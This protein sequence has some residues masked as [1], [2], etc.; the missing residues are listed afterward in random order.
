MMEREKF[1]PAIFE[2]VLF[3]FTLL[4]SHGLLLDGN[5]Y[6][7]PDNPRYIHTGEQGM[8]FVVWQVD[9]RKKWFSCECGLHAKQFSPK[10]PNID[11]CQEFSRLAPTVSSY[12]SIIQPPILPWAPCI[13]LSP[14]LWLDSSV[15]GCPLPPFNHLK[16]FLDEAGLLQF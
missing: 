7:V 13:S 11:L 8:I 2:Y 16:R 10:F 12:C 15:C 3:K 14:F 1:Q 5:S 6:H 9:K 4:F